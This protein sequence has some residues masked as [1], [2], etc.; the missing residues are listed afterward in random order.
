MADTQIPVVP[1]EVVKK[2]RKYKRLPLGEDNQLLNLG[3]IRIKSPKNLVIISFPKSGKTKTIVNVPKILIADAEKGTEYFNANNKVNLLDDN[4]E[5]QFVQ[6]KNNKYGYIPKTIYDLVIELYQANKMSD[7]WALQNK[8]DI[9]RDLTIKQS[10]YEELISKINE[11][12]FPIV[13]LDTIT[14]LVSLSNAAALYEYN[15]H[16][17]PENRKAD[18]KRIDE[19]GGVSKIRTKFNDIK[20]F[21]EQNAS[22]FIIY[23]GHIGMKK[24]LINKSAEEA[25]VLDIALEGV[26]STIFTSKA[27]SVC[28]FY[29]NETGCWLDFTKKEE[30]ALGSRPAHL[31]NQLIKIADILQEGEET[32]ITYWQKIYPEIN[33]NK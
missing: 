7:Y 8:F 31:S 28:T 15:L 23:M 20:N 22:P 6:T 10:L 2:E 17:K 3:D 5:G 27:D 26:L 21:I 14:S 32:P 13:A 9:E 12:P 16:M 19:Y 30:T 1:E 24:K 18:I 25:T 11:M 33:F 4:T 29:R